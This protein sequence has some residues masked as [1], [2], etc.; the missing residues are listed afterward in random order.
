MKKIEAIIRSSKL[1]EVKE[2]LFKI[3]IPT[4][5]TYE[6]KIG[7][8][9][10]AHASWR[11]RFVKPSDLLPKTKIEILCKDGDAENIVNTVIKFS[12]TGQTGDGLVYIYDLDSIQKIKNGMTGES[13]IN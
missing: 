3:G 7:G 2:E 4:I 10:S 8:L 13:A 1:F 12:R 6:V 5:T 9:Y 11:Q